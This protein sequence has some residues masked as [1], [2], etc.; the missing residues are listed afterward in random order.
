MKL[1]PKLGRQP[2]TEPGE[3]ALQA[4]NVKFDWSRTE[5]IWMKREPIASHVLNALSMLLPEGERMFLVTFDEALELVKDE[6]LRE[7][8]IG[9]IGQE[10]MHAESHNGALEEVLATHGIDVEPYVR[11]AEFIFRKTLGPR[12][13]ATEAARQQQLVERLGVIAALEHFFAFL[14]DW[15]INAD[16][17]KFDADPQMLDLFRWHGA[18]EVEHRMVAHDVAEYFEI[19][20]VRRGALMLMVFPIFIALLL[21]GT[22]FLVHAD[23]SLPNHRYPMLVMRIFAGMWRRSI[24]GI[25]SLLISA[26][27]TFKP[28]YSPE[29]VGS[30]AQAV[31]YLAKSPAARALAS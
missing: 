30:T 1:L 27:S 2:V 26:L 4:R 9:F 29:G 3:V 21:R 23:P 14:G 5:P 31:A 15:V 19:G 28:G 18:E 7:A 13:A 12:E 17:E 24:P 16:L 20:Y 22:K 8:M 25:P 10:S 11:Q 6:K